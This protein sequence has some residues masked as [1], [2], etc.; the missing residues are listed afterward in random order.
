MK[1]SAPNGPARRYRY[2]FEPYSL[3]TAARLL[4]KGH[5]SLALAPKAVE[6]LLV[7]VERAGQVVSRD[8]LLESVWPDAFVEPNNLAQQFRWCARR[9][10]IAGSARSTSKLFRA[11]DIASLPP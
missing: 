6:T 10:M 4:S 9:S 8:E 1:S 7:L 2:T 5:E 11:G 3:D